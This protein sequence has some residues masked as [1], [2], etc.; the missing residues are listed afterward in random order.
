MPHSI[1]SEASVEDKDLPDAPSQP[2]SPATGESDTMDVSKDEETFNKAPAVSLEELF[3]QDNDD[4][5]EFGS[6][7]PVVIVQNDLISSSPPP[8]PQ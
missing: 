4:D 8:L 6:S 3:D 1:S 5:D 7:A 2:E